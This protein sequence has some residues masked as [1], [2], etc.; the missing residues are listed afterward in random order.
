M[1]S[2]L[3][4]GQTNNITLIPPPRVRVH[5]IDADT[6]KPL[7][8]ARIIPGVADH[9][10]SN[11]PEWRDDSGVNDLLHTLPDGTR[12]PRLHR[13]HHDLLLVRA[14]DDTHA[15]EST[16]PLPFDGHDYALTL[17]LH[18]ADHRTGPLLNPDGSS[19]PNALISLATHFFDIYNN[20]EPLGININSPQADPA[21]NALTDKDGNFSFPPQ[22]DPFTLLV[23]ADKGGALLSSKKFLRAD[24]TI[25][26]KPWAFLSGTVLT[27]N[28]TPARAGLDI[29]AATP[30][31]QAD[32]PGADTQYHA[33]T[34]AHGHFSFLKMFPGEYQIQVQRDI[35]NNAQGSATIK[36]RPNQHATLNI[37]LTN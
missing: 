15:P 33:T 10:Y 30:T 35:T 17:P 37:P 31:Y 11:H 27:P 4:P 19:A 34:D 5:V 14:T 18:N 36:L 16:R 29:Q 13:A 26:L 25:T 2:P 21:H 28:N 24:N 9:R 3:T 20:D 23:I 32:N 8:N 1:H 22:I 12:A 7:P 6:G